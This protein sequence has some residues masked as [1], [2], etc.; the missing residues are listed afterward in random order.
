[1]NPHF[2][3]RAFTLIELLVVIAII[4]IL[5]AMLLPA[6]QRVREAANMT[7][8]RNNLHQIGLALHHYHD[9]RKSFPMGSW[10]GVPFV[11]AGDTAN[12]RG[13]TWLIEMLPYLEES[14][15]YNNL[16]NDKVAT[17]EGSGSNNPKNATWFAR[18]G[19]ISVLLCPSSTCPTT[20]EPWPSTGQAPPNCNA[21]LVGLCVPSYVGISGADMGYYEGDALRFKTLKPE[22]VY[23]TAFGSV[24][25]DGVLVPCRTVS[26]KDI[27]DGTSNTIA[28]GEQSDWGELDG[29][30]ADIRS[31]AFVGG[32]FGVGDAGF[33]AD[34]Q[35]EPPD[36]VRWQHVGIYQA[37]SAALT[38]VRWPLNFKKL[39]L[40]PR[41][42]QWAFGGNKWVDCHA[43]PRCGGV[44]SGLRSTELG[45]PC[46]KRG[47]GT[48]GNL[49]LQ[50]AHTGGAM[51]LFA[52]GHVTFMSDGYAREGMVGLAG[53]GSVLER[54]CV[55][56]DGLTVDLPD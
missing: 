4:A 27:T 26:V 33:L 16:F 49:P 44:W 54:L 19:P 45:P 37:T 1:M 14:P 39:V 31:S 22:F 53:R 17:F 42:Y 9:A 3:R 12:V 7:Q 23:N 35:F 43:G 41:C 50:S 2:T 34:L 6:V 29:T 47:F 28:V 38:T 18:R 40:P 5:I 8:C 46:T 10:N 11:G 52:D 36:P 15:L 30:R 55:R 51:V 32:F 24:A 21:G 56:N 20:T 25:T 13:G 48:G